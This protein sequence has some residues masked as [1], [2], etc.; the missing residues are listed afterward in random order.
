M[1][2]NELWGKACEQ[3]KQE[4][5]QVSYHTWI[6]TNLT[7]KSLEGDVLTLIEKAQSDFDQKKALE[8]AQKMKLAD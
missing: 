2:M 6:E 4:M 1:D 8:M 3:L 7:P 5:N